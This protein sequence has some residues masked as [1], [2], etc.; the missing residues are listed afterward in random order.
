MRITVD[1]VRGM[2]TEGAD[3]DM[4]LLRAAELPG[5]TDVRADA[6]WFA[7]TKSTASDITF[8]LL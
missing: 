2:Q 7:V 1:V 5:L 8:M 3:S 6:D 4:D